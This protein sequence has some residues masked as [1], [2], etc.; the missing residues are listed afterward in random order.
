MYVIGDEWECNLSD[1]E[2]H[3]VN[4]DENNVYGIRNLDYITANT[5]SKEASVITEKTTTP[6]YNSAS[7]LFSDEDD[8]SE[9]GVIILMSNESFN[10]DE[11]NELTTIQADISNENNYASNEIE[12][13]GDGEFS[14]S[15]ESRT[16]G[17]G[18]LPIPD[19]SK[20]NDL[21]THLQRLQQLVKNYRNENQVEKNTSELGPDQLN[22]FLSEQNIKAEAVDESTEDPNIE[23]LT[24][25]ADGKIHVEHLNEIIKK[26]NRLTLDSATTETPSIKKFYVDR[27]PT[28]LLRL[29]AGEAANIDPNSYSNHQI[30]VNRPGGSVL[31]NV[32]EPISRPNPYISEEVLKSI[33]EL[34]KQISS[35]NNYNTKSGSNGYYQP[36]MKPVYYPIPI[37]IYS[38][39]Q[40]FNSFKPS[41]NVNLNT[42]VNTVDTTENSTKSNYTSSPI[43][44]YIPKK[45]TLR[46]QTFSNVP[47]QVLHKDSYGQYYIPKEPHHPNYPNL[48]DNSYHYPHST[49]YIQYPPYTS[50]DQPNIY[51][52]SPSYNGN[53]YVSQWN[54]YHQTFPQTNN[55]NPNS[56]SPGNANNVP[57]YSSYKKPNQQSD[58]DTYRPVSY[59]NYDT[60]LNY[61]DTVD[62][63]NEAIVTDSSASNL[64]QSEQPSFDDMISTSDEDD[65]KKLIQIAG[66]YFNYN[67]YKDTL[68]PLLQNDDKVAI[69]TCTTVRQ[70]N[71]TDCTRYYICNPSTQ[72]V[73][74]YI[75]PLRTAFNTA[76]KLCD[77]KTYEECKNTPKPNVDNSGMQLRINQYQIEKQAALAQAHRIH[78]ETIKAQNEVNRIR[79][80]KI[81]SF[82][83]NIPLRLNTATA[84][85][86]QSPTIST[87]ATE[88]EPVNPE[89]S[90]VS[91]RKQK[92]RKPRCRKPGRMENPS[93]PQKYYVCFKDENEHLRRRSMSC[94]GD[95]VFCKSTSFCTLSA[96]CYS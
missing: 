30:V 65:R 83:N 53:P 80:M 2:N 77:I 90:G 54:N 52:P 15:M 46:N 95:L 32:P 4:D 87:Q 43:T 92:R 23:K 56:Y 63:D 6:D 40:N 74:S 91:I 48:N 10:S 78:M 69:I 13:S 35:N 38:N 25:P 82:M 33:I 20:A 49:Q 26:Q 28:S 1:N 41:E 71:A 45:P 55:Y 96:R 37:P 57:F 24:I 34:S 12:Y 8:D 60:H 84:N 29:K 16:E 5:A 93:S 94:T 39:S 18:D 61:D 85:N 76:A 67:E 9:E 62:E 47:T 11:S 17:S 68:L 58:D 36:I 51:Q 75:C 59:L 88:Q 64:E 14:D 79:L 70:P 66:N 50:F 31:F 86:I 44:V 81:K 42:I 89:I 3:Y 27:N 21:T 7:E 72:K 73:I 22:A 19:T